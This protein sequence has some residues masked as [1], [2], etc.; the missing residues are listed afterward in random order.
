MQKFVG[1]LIVNLIEPKSKHR[2]LSGNKWGLE[3]LSH[4][5][6]Y[7]RHY[8]LKL[9]LFAPQRESAY[10]QMALFKAS[11]NINQLEINRKTINQ[12]H[13]LQIADSEEETKTNY[14]SSLLKP[15]EHFK[16]NEYPLLRRWTVVA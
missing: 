12:S 2:W 4:F 13:G 15:L 8:R 14:S 6:L 10:M 1:R 11:P 16:A 9:I 5:A 3:R 7:N